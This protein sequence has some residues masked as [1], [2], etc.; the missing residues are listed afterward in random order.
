MLR[1][2]TPTPCGIPPWVPFRDSRNGSDNRL[3]TIVGAIAYGRAER[4]SRMRIIQLLFYYIAQEKLGLKQK[5][6]PH[7]DLSFTEFI[8]RPLDK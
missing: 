5:G 4:R 1:Q 8:D 2:R 6:N 3:L 7:W